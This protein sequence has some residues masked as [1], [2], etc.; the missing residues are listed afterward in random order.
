M[1]TTDEQL[2]KAGNHATD[3]RQNALPLEQI[4]AAARGLPMVLICGR[5]N[6]GKSTLFNRIVGAQRAIV[7]EIPGATRDLNFARAR[8]GE[9]EFA[10]V[11]SGGLGP[12][13]EESLGERLARR[14][15]EVARAADAI[16]FVVD[17]K[18]G[19]NPADAEALRALR[20]I[21]RPFLL[22]VNKL[23]R[24]AMDL[25]AGEFHALGAEQV[26][27][28][29]AA[30]GRG[31][32]EL[33]EA[34]MAL[35]PQQANAAA[36]SADELRFALIGRPNV[37]KSSLVN[38]LAG[39]E[40]SAVDAAAGTTRD[41]VDVAIRFS[42]RSILLIDTGGVRRPA[43]IA[44][45]LE[46]RV[47]A[48]ALGT[49]RRAEV[50]GLVLDAAQG[51]TDQDARLAAMVERHD[52]ALMLI[53]NKWDLAAAQQQT[54]DRFR[55]DLRERCAFVDYAPVVF[56]SALT[57]DGVSDIPRVALKV[58]ESFR[59]VFKTAQLNRILSET[60]GAVEP[61]IVGRRRLKPMYVTQTATAPARLLVFA[62]LERDVPSH[63]LRFLQSRFRAALGI[64]G[65][66]LRIELRRAGSARPKASSTPDAGD[67]LDA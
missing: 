66:P 59:A 31:V 36:Q 34:L 1:T 9:R 17:G 8:E 23:D 43:R 24:P 3:Q 26:F 11:D 62:N 12:Q 42:D 15:L 63:Y 7:S 64:V 48:R 13:G 54:V 58:G 39:F 20:R 51:F 30:H 65:A 6:V 5:P 53:V 67:K 45:D 61:P 2:D 32:G 29:S 57:G 19:L 52:R 10:I 37:G 25:L 22:A 50:L 35:L 38:R 14:T 16:I 41:P 60:V 18:E 27:P 47:V 55:R 21:N 56:C 40:R 49:V 46:Q 4:R 33:L 28:V 44:C